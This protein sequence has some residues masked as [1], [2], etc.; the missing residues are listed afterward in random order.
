MNIIGQVA[1]AERTSEEKAKAAKFQEFG[2]TTCHQIVPGE[3]ALTSYGKKM[4]S[5][6]LPGCTTDLCCA[7]PRH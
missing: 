4:K 5:L 1:P 2:C 3:M 6:H 7:T